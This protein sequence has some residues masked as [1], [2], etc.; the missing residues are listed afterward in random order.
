M[1]VLNI[2][3]M[4]K[5]LCEFIPLCYNF[6]SYSLR[7]KPVSTNLRKETHDLFPLA[8]NLASISIKIVTHDVCG[9]SHHDKKR[10]N[11]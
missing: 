2:L 8:K 6:V 4:M 5:K 7:A 9:H 1:M 10:E 3:T 11:P